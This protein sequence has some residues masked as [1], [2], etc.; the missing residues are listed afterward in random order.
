MTVQRYSEEESVQRIY[1]LLKGETLSNDAPETLTGDKLSTNESLSRIAELLQ[2]S[3]PGEAASLPSSIGRYGS[4]YGNNV[5]IVVDVVVSG[6]FYLVSGTVTQGELNG[7]TFGAGGKLFVQ[8]EGNYLI[9]YSLGLF[10]PSISNVESAVLL[11]GVLVS[12]STSHTG[13]LTSSIPSSMG[14]T[15]ILE[16]SAGSWLALAVENHM[17]SDNITVQHMTFTIHKI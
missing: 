1:R 3:L 11:D 10:T 7:F 15:C 14:G 4:M 8:E 5:T 9:T 6:T 12:G 17:N 2:G 16:L 13:V